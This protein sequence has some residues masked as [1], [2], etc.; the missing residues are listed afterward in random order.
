MGY[1]RFII[2]GDVWS[3]TEKAG[4]LTQPPRGVVPPDCASCFW[5]KRRNCRHA[6]AN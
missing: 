1:A 4:D 2:S 6:L 3:I 5:P